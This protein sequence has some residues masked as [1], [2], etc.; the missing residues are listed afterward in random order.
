MKKIL[1]ILH[2]LKL[3]FFAEFIIS[4]YSKLKGNGCKLKYSKPFWSSKTKAEYFYE[5]SLIDH[6]QSVETD[7][8]ELYDDIFYNQYTLKSGD[9]ICDVVSGMGHD[10][11]R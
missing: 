2:L 9:I 6:R 10:F 1:H 7:V 4:F 8:F 11:Y 5:D 3:L